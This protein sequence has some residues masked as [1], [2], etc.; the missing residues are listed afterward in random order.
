MASQEALPLCDL[1]NASKIGDLSR[2]NVILSQ[3]RANID[4]QEWIGRTPVIWAALKG[5]REVVELL[6]TKG[7]NVKLT[8][9]FGINILHSACL[10]GDVDVVK[11]FHSHD[12]ADIDSRAQCK[13]TPMMLAAE[14]GHKEV[15]ELLVGEGADMSLVDKQHDNIFNC[16]IRGGHVKVMKHIVSQNKVGINSRGW[17]KK[18]PVMVAAEMGGKDV[19]EFL[20]ELGADLS[21]V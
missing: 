11:Y 7:A 17:K 2:V 16:A 21:L 14:N 18:T 19:V 13:R 20:M 4:C 1:H 6:V 10:G 8:D 5:Y 9:R 15:V 3:G 12:M